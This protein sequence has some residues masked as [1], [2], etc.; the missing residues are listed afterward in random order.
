[1][2]AFGF[3]NVA[4]QNAKRFVDLLSLGDS[5]G[6]VTFADPSPDPTATPAADRAKV[7]AQLT[8][9]DDP[10]DAA[11]VRNAIEGITFGGWTPIGAGLLKSA[12][13]LAGAPPRR[14]CCSSPMVM[15]T[16][17]PASPPH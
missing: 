9:L 1:M 15:R 6:V 3:D 2:T 11:A 12:A 14:R 4:R 5:T 13:L 16:A 8:L 17:T 7:E 10:G